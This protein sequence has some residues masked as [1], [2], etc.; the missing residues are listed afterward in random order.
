MYV[1][2]HN[3]PPHA[4]HRDDLNAS[5]SRSRPTQS[6]LIS[7][8]VSLVWSERPREARIGRRGRQ[9]SAGPALIGPELVRGPSP[10]DPPQPSETSTH[11]WRRTAS[12]ADARQ[13]P[14]PVGRP[15]CQSQRCPSAIGH[16][17]CRSAVH[18]AWIGAAARADASTGSVLK[19]RGERMSS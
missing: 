1:L 18:C 6:P 16:H 13:C 8:L 4:A 3:A 9:C 15:N 11:H 19:A 7:R 14:A 5:R 12:F 10:G 17:G 2:P